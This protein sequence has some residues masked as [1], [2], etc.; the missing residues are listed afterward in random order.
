MPSRIELMLGGFRFD[1]GILCATEQITLDAAAITST[2]EVSQHPS[3]QS[4][5]YPSW[6]TALR[7]LKA[8]RQAREPVRHERLRGRSFTHISGLNALSVWRGRSGRRY[9]VVVYTRAQLDCRLADTQTDLAEAVILAVRTNTTPGLVSI[10]A[11]SEGLCGPNAANWLASMARVGIDE[12]HV[13]RLAPSLTDRTAI[14]LD[15]CTPDL[16]ALP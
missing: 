3:E 12:F 14:L 11:A 4:M 2:V 6:H 16:E 7:A 5:T 13:H 1:R 8:D 9:I 10:I 15:V